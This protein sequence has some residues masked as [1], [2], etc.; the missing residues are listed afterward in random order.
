MQHLLK[1]IS[2]EAT[3]L[4]PIAGINSNKT[5][6]R[7][8]LDAALQI[9][10]RQGDSIRSS[11]YG[12]FHRRVDAAGFS[13][14]SPLWSIPSQLPCFLRRRIIVSLNLCRGKRWGRAEWLLENTTL[15]NSPPHVR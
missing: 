3:R 10:S 14:C 2:Y 5:L 8:R 7:L 12:V 11:S 1:V 13:E 4:I 9:D 6:F 15:Q